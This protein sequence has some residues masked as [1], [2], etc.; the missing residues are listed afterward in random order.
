MKQ[1]IP[2]GAILAVIGLI[3]LAYPFFT[4]QQT[5]EV[6][7]VGPLHV[8]ENQQQ[9]HEVPPI[10]SGGILAVGVVMLAGGLMK[11]E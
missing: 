2:I 11:N 1:F 9:T 6:A 4:T 5:K 3:L 10:L 7:H 8:D